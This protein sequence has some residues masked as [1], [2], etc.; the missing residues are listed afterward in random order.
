MKEIRITSLNLLTSPFGWYQAVIENRM[1]QYLTW[2][3]ERDL[4]TGD[5]VFR[6]DENSRAIKE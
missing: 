4:M 2:E 6:Y 1:R 3:Y 5:I